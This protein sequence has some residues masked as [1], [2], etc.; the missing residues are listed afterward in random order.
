MLGPHLMTWPAMLSA[1]LASPR[2]CVPIHMQDEQFEFQP[3]CTCSSTSHVIQLLARRPKK[4]I[5][6]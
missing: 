5:Q 3:D 1:V 2:S 6:A 4:A